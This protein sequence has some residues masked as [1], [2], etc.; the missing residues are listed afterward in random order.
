MARALNHFLCSRDVG[1]YATLVLLKLFPN[2][3]L[4]YM[5]CGH[6]PPLSILGTEIRKLEESNL[7]VGLIPDATYTSSVCMLRIGERVLLPTDGLTEAEDSNG[8][9]F[10]E[11][12]LRA[13]VPY[14][15]IDEIL[16][17]VARFRAPNPAE[18]DCTIVEIKYVQN[19]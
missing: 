18:D 14:H 11:A 8:G 13:C 3:K 5:N 1:K 12:G 7:V 16:E 9:E 6:V 17:L 15:N 10:G 19:S 4:E 2:G